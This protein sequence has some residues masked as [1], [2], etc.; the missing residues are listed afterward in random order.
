M[1]TVTCPPSRS[2]DA[3]PAEYGTCVIEMPAWRLMLSPIMCD[4]EPVPK[5]A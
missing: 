4:G 1:A 3:L 5:E 2:T